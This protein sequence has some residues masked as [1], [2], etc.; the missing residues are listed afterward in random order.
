MRKIVIANLICLLVSIN[1]KETLR[2]GAMV[3]QEGP[4]DLAGFLP[5]M[6]LALE[7]IEDDETLFFDFEIT[8]NDSMVS[9]CVRNNV[10][11]CGS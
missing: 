11:L 6:E 5:A 2:L 9:E 1:A 8:L 10:S 7:T 4:F 3:S